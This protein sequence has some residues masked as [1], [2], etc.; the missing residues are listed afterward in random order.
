MK[1]VGLELN[2]EKTKYMLLPRH[3]NADQNRDIK[4]ANKSFEN[5]SP[6]KY[7]GTTVRDQNL[8]E[9]EIERKLNFGIACYYWVQNFVFSSVIIKRKSRN[10]RDYNFV[11]ERGTEED[12]RTE[13]GWGDGRVKETA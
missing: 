10:I 8:F 4:I 9:E 7:L 11:W 6:F 3:Q 13:E 2:V 12:I 5:V 1:E